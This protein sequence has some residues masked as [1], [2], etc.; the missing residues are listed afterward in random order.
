MLSSQ[1]SGL[2]H[3][4]LPPC[5]SS[6][7]NGC[8]QVHQSLTGCPGSSSLKVL[9]VLSHKLIDTMYVCMYAVL[10]MSLT[11]VVCI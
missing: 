7:S 8:S 2:L 1:W 3:L 5:T 6:L 4:T 11:Y 9:V 10:H